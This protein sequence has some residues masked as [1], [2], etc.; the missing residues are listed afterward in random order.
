M[1]WIGILVFMGVV[2]FSSVAVAENCQ[3]IKRKDLMQKLDKSKVESVLTLSKEIKS[4]SKGKGFECVEPLIVDFISFYN[5]SLNEFS[6]ANDIDSL[7][8]PMPDNKRDELVSRIAKVGWEI[9]ELKVKGP[10][11]TIYFIAEQGD[12]ISKEFEPI[13]SQ[14]WKDYFALV[15]VELKE[16]FLSETDI[17]LVSWEKLC[18]QIIKWDKFMAEYPEFPLTGS[19]QYY[20]AVYVEKLLIGPEPSGAND[21]LHPEVKKEFERFIKVNTK[22][23]YH[24]IV[25]E[26]YDFLSKNDFMINEGTILFLTQDHVRSLFD[27]EPPPDY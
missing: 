3:E 16:A 25:K 1:K 6:E 13:L 24:P 21:K 5:Q 23:K 19:I 12:W 14:S 11:E 26:Y 27:V 22:S 4:Y 7:S 17:V 18:D 15:A 9:R 10:E 20:Q 2:T 8:Y